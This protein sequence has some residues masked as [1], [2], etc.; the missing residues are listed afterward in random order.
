MSKS[1]DQRRHNRGNKGADEA[2]ANGVSRV[3]FIRNEYAE[4]SVAEQPIRSRI[5]GYC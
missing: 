5:G 1:V 3:T 4:E 2:A